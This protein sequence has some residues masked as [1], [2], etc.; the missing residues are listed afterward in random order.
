MS[1]CEVVEAAHR[2]RARHSAGAT[3]SATA[4]SDRVIHAHEPPRAPLSVEIRASLARA[5]AEFDDSAFGA[6][7][8]PALPRALA[9]A[10]LEATPQALQQLLGAPLQAT[11]RVDWP[12]FLRL[13]SA[14]AALEGRGREQPEPADAAHAL[15]TVRE[16]QLPAPLPHATAFLS[17][18]EP[19]GDAPR[20]D[21]LSLATART[22]VNWAVRIPLDR[23]LVLRLV[24]QPERKARSVLDPAPV[25]LLRAELKAQ[26]LRAALE[27]ALRTSGQAELQLPLADGKAE[28]GVLLVTVWCWDRLPPHSPPRREAA[29]ARRGAT[30]GVAA[31]AKP[32]TVPPRPDAAPSPPATPRA[33]NGSA[34]RGDLEQRRLQIS[35]LR[36]SSCLIFK[37]GEFEERLR[38]SF[39]VADA[40]GDGKLSRRELSAALSAVGLRS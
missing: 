35:L 26:S 6:I 18:G 27:A 22:G 19:R 28:R 15:L 8:E 5:F 23:S 24:A 31:T 30:N 33:E 3:T 12:A 37:S 38:R 4:T 7:A 17:L 1:F 11:R 21:S 13:A 14:L 10:G 29:P 36:D 25:E 40:D 32:S 2:M 16:L 20:S 34:A 39:G 9:A